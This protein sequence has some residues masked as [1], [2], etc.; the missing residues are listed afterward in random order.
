MFYRSWGQFIAQKSLL[1][2]LLLLASPAVG[3]PVRERKPISVVNKDLGTI[4]FGQLVLDAENL[5]DIGVLR[6]KYL[7]IFN[8]ELARHGYDVESHGSSVFKMGEVPQADFV[9]AGRLTDFDCVS[10][11]DETCGVEIRWELLRTASKTVVYRV[12]ARHEESGLDEMDDQ[13]GARRLLIGGLHSLLS[14]SKFVA[15][16]EGAVVKSTA[17]YDVTLLKRCAQQPL[18]MPDASEEAIAA[19]VMVK[20]DEGVG[21]GVL[22][23]PDGFILTAAHVVPGTEAKVRLK[24]GEL[25]GAK[26]IRRSKKEDIALIQMEV[27]G[28]ASACLQLRDASPKAGEAVYAIGSPAGEEFSFSISRGVVSG[29]RTLRGVTYVQTDA[30]IN[31]GN[32]GGPIVGSDGSVL[33]VVS[34]KVGGA[35]FEGMG[36]AIPASTSKR[37]LNFD[38]A[39]ESSSAGSPLVADTPKSHSTDDEPD[40]DWY[41]VGVDAPGK[42]PGWVIPV[43]VLGFVSLG[44]SIPT[45]IIGTQVVPPVQNC[46]IDGCYYEVLVAGIAGAAIGGGMVVGSYV[47]RPKQDPYAHSNEQPQIAFGVGPTSAFVHG[48]F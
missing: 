11:K 41:Y 38:F 7:D 28:D 26:V 35:D 42:R 17:N 22:V 36:F 31:P 18:N 14:R 44:L 9:L 33:G 12:T 30:S 46:R 32:S 23:S 39:D 24:N 48:T 2:L 19:T 37:A 27:T 3:A 13:T 20:S 45:I 29:K 15:A 6:E 4:T 34:W 8:D 47:L 10:E 43:R 21:A 16:M 1:L 40:Q 5:G 25:R